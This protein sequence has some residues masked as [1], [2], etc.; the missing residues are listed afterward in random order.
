MAE[1]K[2]SEI[3][4]EHKMEQKK[5]ETKHEHKHE[6]KKE[7][8]KPEVKKGKKDYATVYAGNLHMGYKVGADICSMIRNRNI[9]DAIKMVEEVMAFKRAVKTNKREAPHKPGEGMMAGR[10]PVKAC[11]EFL[12]ILKQL[13]ANAMYH[14]LEIEKCN[15]FCK[16]DRGSQQYRRGGARAK[17]ANVLLKLIKKAEVNKKQGEKK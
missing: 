13:K 5:E 15:I 14:E 4:K 3:K 6:E 16:A 1:E 8:K 7:E 2:K 12:K 17:R 10:Y 11:G 9:D